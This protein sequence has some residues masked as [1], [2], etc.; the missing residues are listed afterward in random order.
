MTPEGDSKIPLTRIERFDCSGQLVQRKEQ[1][2]ISEEELFI[3]K[4]FFQLLINLYT[5]R[6]SSLS[7][8]LASKQGVCHPELVSVPKRQPA[9]QIDLNSSELPDVVKTIVKEDTVQKIM[10]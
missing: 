2:L 7:E 5:S 10:Y 1:I 6:D 4:R 8:M 3:L 9:V